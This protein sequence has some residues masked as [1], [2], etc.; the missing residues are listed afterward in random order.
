MKYKVF[1]VGLVLAWSGVLPAQTAIQVQEARLAIPFGAASGKVVRVGDFLVFIDDERPEWSFAISRGEVENV[2]TEGDTLTVKTMKPLRDRT[3]ERTS[4]AFQLIGGADMATGL[5]QWARMT[6]TAAPADTVRPVS[7]GAAATL[8]YQARHKHGL[9]F[10][11][12]CQ[13]RLIV[14]E[15]RISY[16]SV[17]QIEHSRQWELRDI[18]EFKLDN[19]Y[20]IHIDLFVGDDYDFELAGKGINSTEYKTIVDRITQARIAR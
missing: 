20:E 8:N 6:A 9:P 7:N 3:G 12:S 15:D 13:G 10:R 5:A 2:A 19:P 18:K 4:F 1:F 17:D 11:G 14:S 16:E